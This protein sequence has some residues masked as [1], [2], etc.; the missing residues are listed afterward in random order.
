METNALVTVGMIFYNDGPKMLSEAIQACHN[1]GLR[2]I[3]VDG[4]F[5]EFMK[6]AGTDTPYSTDGCIDVAKAEADL[7]IPC[8]EHGWPDQAQKRNE[9]VKPIEN[10][11]YF[12]VLDA[13]EFL[14]EHTLRTDYDADWYVLNEK[15]VRRHGLI[16]DLHFIRMHKKYDD[17]RYLYVHYRLYRT[18]THNPNDIMSGL[19]HFEHAPRG[20]VY[21]FLY[22]VNGKIVTFIHDT[23]LRSEE[24]RRQKE[25]YYFTR[26]EKALAFRY[27][28]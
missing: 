25:S 6:V 8:P 28:G 23:T 16:R 21:P 12:L 5:Q 15:R 14:R 27:R 1:S 18:D 4:A 20:I 22:D 26:G 10:G 17:L 19:S 9:Y 3:A 11:K 13:D 2:V 24:R 7:Y